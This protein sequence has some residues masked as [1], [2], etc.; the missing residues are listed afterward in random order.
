M[1]LA[2]SHLFLQHYWWIIISFLASILVFLLF[3]QGGQTLIYTLG[4]NEKER[5]LI[6]NTLGR[7]WETTFTTLVTF[8]G[9]FFAA[10]PLFYSTSFG[11]AY[12]AWMAILIC[13]TIQAFS[14]E[15]RTKPNNFLGQRTFE[16]FLF[17]NGALGTFL[18]G[19]VVSTLFTGAEFSVNKLQ[20]ANLKNPVI[21]SWENGYHGLEA[22]VNFQNICLGFAVFFLARVLA[23][24]YFINQVDNEAVINRT[25]NQLWLNS[26]PFVLFFLAF[27]VQLLLMQGY[28]YD[29]ANSKVFSE[30]YKY[31]YNLTSQPWLLILTVIGIALVLYGI[32]KSLLSKYLKGIWFA[33]IGVVITVFSLFILAG[34]NNT[35]YYPSTFDPQSSLTIENSSSSL[36]TLKA[37]AIVSLIVPFVVAYIY[38]AWKAINNKKISSEELEKESHIY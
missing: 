34:F 28:S 17:I 21:S 5:T 38:F 3:V 18:L 23:L 22:L 27:L 19:V 16:I 10:F 26:I 31:L 14:Y 12:W 8:G 11:G 6:V 15:Y 36:Y 20:L 29:A 7:K 4:K 25:K 2:V 24:L 32:I 9:A 1:I 30:N 37:M 33:G 13:F 35:C